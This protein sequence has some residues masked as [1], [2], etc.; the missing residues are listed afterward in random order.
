MRIRAPKLTKIYYL[1]V[2]SQILYVF[3]PKVRNVINPTTREMRISLEVNSS[4]D[5]ASCVTRS[6]GF[7]DSIDG[8][9]ISVGDHINH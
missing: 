8:I 9:N 7:G 5:E 1:N 6:D 2:R 4:V 3:F